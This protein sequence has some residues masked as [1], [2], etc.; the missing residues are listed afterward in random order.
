MASQ[1]GAD[2]LHRKKEEVEGRLIG[3][4]RALVAQLSKPDSQRDSRLI[5]SLRRELRDIRAQHT[6]LLKT[7]E[8]RHPAEAAL[9]AEVTPL[10]A[11]QVQTEILGQNQVLVEYVVTDQDTLA[12]V[13]DQAPA[14]LSACRSRERHSMPRFASFI[15]LSSNCAKGGRICST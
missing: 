1:S 4:Q 8:L 11:Q 14:S 6:Q 2:E 13:L 12:F 7:V 5:E 3:K 9:Q 10:G 15:F